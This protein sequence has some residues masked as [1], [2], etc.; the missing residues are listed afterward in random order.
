MRR[1]R[2]KKFETKI[3][4]FCWLSHANIWRWLDAKAEIAPRNRVACT[5]ISIFSSFSL[6]C[7][8]IHFHFLFSVFVWWKAIGPRAEQIDIPVI[9][10]F[11]EYRFTLLFARL[12]VRCRGAMETNEIIIKIK[13]NG[14]CR[15]RTQNESAHKAFVRI[16][17]YSKWWKS[18]PKC[19]CLSFF[20]SGADSFWVACAVIYRWNDDNCH[21]IPLF[22]PR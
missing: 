2:R 4:N 5:A 16:R 9:K 19:K 20:H 7:V 22:F 18:A 21:H 15:V 1:R 11:S 3:H 12:G 10:W 8:F 6:R 13:F 17:I 14:C